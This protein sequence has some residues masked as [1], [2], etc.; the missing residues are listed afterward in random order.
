MTAGFEKI[1][2][3]QFPLVKAA[4]AEAVNELALTIWS[5]DEL[6]CLTLALFLCQNG[7]VKRTPNCL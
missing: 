4:A 1:F 3:R 7:P 6:P 5:V 2:R